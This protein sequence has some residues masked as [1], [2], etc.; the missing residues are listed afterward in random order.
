MTSRQPHTRS[1]PFWVAVSLVCAF[2][3][4]LGLASA[5]A[6]A[7]STAR[8]KL[9]VTSTS[10]A[11]PT[12]GQAFTMKFELT[13]L[14]LP[15]HMAGVGCYARTGTANAPLLYQGTDGTVGTCKWAV[16]SGSSGKPFSGILAAKTDS[17]VWYYRGFDLTV[18]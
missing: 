9:V 4:V 5:P 3:V 7:R 17:G 11:Q 13:R 6:S 2:A 18:N 14:G 8:I 15:L 10:P 1:R 16:A 12:A